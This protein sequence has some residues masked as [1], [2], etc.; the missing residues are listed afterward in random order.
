MSRRYDHRIRNA[1][2][3]SGNPRLFPELDIPASTIRDWLRKGPANVITTPE[4]ERDN[5]D[6]I[7]EIRNLKD[8]LAE[9]QAR[10][11]LITT[12]VNILGFQLQY[13]RVPNADIK[14]K[15]IATIKQAAIVIGLDQCL[16]AVQLSKAPFSA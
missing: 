5:H 15:I 9:A 11:Q 10:A 16:E 2:V 8:Q 3:K 1:T 7:A 4:F 6:L 14:L 13:K 12:T